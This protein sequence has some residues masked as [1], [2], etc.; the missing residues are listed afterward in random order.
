MPHLVDRKPPPF[1]I[2]EAPANFRGEPEARCADTA[3]QREDQQASEMISAQAVACIQVRL[4]P[5]LY[6]YTFSIYTY[7]NIYLFICIYIYLFIYMYI[8]IG[9]QTPATH[10][11]ARD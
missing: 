2:H 4:L 1:G 9:A 8:S 3:L 11:C 6:L 7:K 5:K 10:T